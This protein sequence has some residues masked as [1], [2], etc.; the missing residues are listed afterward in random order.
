MIEKITVEIHEESMSKFKRHA[1]M[2]NLSVAEF[3]SV[4]AL[5]YV[6]QNELVDEFELAQI[7]DDENLLK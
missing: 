1:E 2:E 4:A 3:I 5:R 6:E 7:L